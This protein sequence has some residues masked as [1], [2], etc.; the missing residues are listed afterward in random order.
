[1]EE[2]ADAIKNSDDSGGYIGGVIEDSI[3]ILFEI[4][5]EETDSKMRQ[6]LFAWSLCEAQKKKY[7]D[8]GWDDTLL[9]LASCLI[10]NEKQE[11]ELLDL[12]D[13]LENSLEEKYTDYTREKYAMIKLNLLKQRGNKEGVQQFL[14]A[15]I[16]FT[17]FRKELIEQAIREKDYAA[18]KSL[19]YNGVDYDTKRHYVGIVNDW[20]KYL[21]KIA[22]IEEETET[23]R[24]L[25]LELFSRHNPEIKYYRIWKNTFRGKEKDEQIAKLIDDY[26]K[27]N[28]INILTSILIEEK[29]YKDLLEVVRKSP[30]IYTIEKYEKYLKSQFSE[31]LV[32]LYAQGIISF[33][34]RK[35]G[36]KYYLEACRILRKMKKLGGEKTVERLVAA[37]KEHYKRRPALI[38]ELNSL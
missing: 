17:S 37:L 28:A 11:Q 2:S 6:A 13:K 8:F 22:Q 14:E 20:K 18:A 23:V 38:D 29:R 10:D 26:R 30:N 4:A 5:E 27:K 21:L 24:K 19:A 9:D 3:N 15:N 34:E 7:S 32:K 35:T 36:R 16:H 1:M 25:S 33:L 31:E 12:L